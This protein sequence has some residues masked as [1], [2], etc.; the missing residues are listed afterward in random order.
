MPERP[1]EAAKLNEAEP[2][3]EVAESN[4]PERSDA[5][6][7]STESDPADESGSDAEAEQRRLARLEAAKRRYRA[8]LRNEAET[9]GGGFSEDYYR[10]QKPPHWS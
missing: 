9:G 7:H 6:V 2:A 8:T 4:G 10:S 5:D 3:V 1:D